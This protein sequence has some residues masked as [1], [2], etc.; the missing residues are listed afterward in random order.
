MRPGYAAPGPGYAHPGFVGTGVGAPGPGYPNAGYGG[1]PPTMSEAEYRDLALIH[2]G[3][4]LVGG[5]ARGLRTPGGD[6]LSLV[7]DTGTGMLNGAWW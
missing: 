7:A 5:L 6:G 2:G 1:P 3:F 4:G